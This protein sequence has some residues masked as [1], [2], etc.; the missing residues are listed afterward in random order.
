LGSLSTGSV[1]A[2]SVDLDITS[3]ASNGYSLYLD[4]VNDNGFSTGTDTIAMTTGTLS[5]GTPGAGWSLDVSGENL[6]YNG[7]SCPGNNA[8][9]DIGTD[10]FQVVSV[11]EPTSQIYN[12]CFA[13]AVG[14]T[15]PAGNYNHTAQLTFVANY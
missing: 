2:N 9:T 4:D 1:T 8:V 6:A 5:A 12:F 7:G 10:S 14:T 15:T 3:N 13:A 11:S